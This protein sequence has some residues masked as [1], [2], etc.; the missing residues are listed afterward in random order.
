MPWIEHTEP[1]GNGLPP[2][3]RL[4]TPWLDAPIEFSTTGKAD[5]PE[6]IADLLDLFVVEISHSDSASPGSAIVEGQTAGPDL[7]SLESLV[8]E[9]TQ[10]DSLTA[11]DAFFDFI[12]SERC[13]V[14]A[15]VDVRDPRQR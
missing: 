13:R 4:E 7:V 3:R 9:T 11:T 2:I 15:H 8:D 10:L 14:G 1:A 6:Q 5:V 12:R